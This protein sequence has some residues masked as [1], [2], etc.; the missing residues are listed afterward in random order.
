MLSAQIL[1]DLGARLGVEGGSMANWF[2]RYSGPDLVVGMATETLTVLEQKLGIPEGQPIR[3]TGWGVGFDVAYLQVNED[4]TLSASCIQLM[5]LKPSARDEPHNDDGWQVRQM[6]LAYVT[7]QRMDRPIVTHVQALSAPTQDDIN[8]II[9]MLRSRGVPHMACINNVYIGL[10]EDETGRFRYDPSADAGMLLEFAPTYSEA[11]P[12]FI[13]PP[14]LPK[15]PEVVE[16]PRG[17]LVRPTARTQLVPSADAVIDRFREMLDW[18]EDE[19]LAIREGDGYRSVSILPM[20]GLSAVWELIEPTRPDSRPAKVMERYGPG[21]W[22][23]RLGVYGLDEKLED[24]ERRGTRWDW[25]DGGP[26]G[27]RAAVNR[28]DLRGVPIELEELPVV[29]RGVGGG[30]T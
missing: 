10:V 21:P 3:M 25:I 8:E 24:L 28:W 14:R 23:I 12:N 16:L 13:A 4:P 17:T 27:R 9:E 6:L 7:S 11:Y 26:S 5:S 15:N 19:H 30:R 2:D 18:P 22:T 1:A 29:H 20:N